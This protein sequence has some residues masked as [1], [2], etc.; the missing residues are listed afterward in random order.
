[1][2]DPRRPKFASEGGLKD[3]PPVRELAGQAKRADR[4]IRRASRHPQ[5]GV[6]G[7][8]A[9]RLSSE[10]RMPAGHT[11]PLSRWDRMIL[12]DRDL[13]LAQYLAFGLINSPCASPTASGACAARA[14]G[15]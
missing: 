4:H 6:P 11:C 13:K 8:K 3:P 10:R 5:K 12:S 9:R 2:L 14:R 15:D 1:M 7:G